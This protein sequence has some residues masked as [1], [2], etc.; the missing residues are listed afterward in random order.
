LL[1][2]FWRWGLT[3]YL[4]GLASH[5]DPPN[6]SLPSSWDY[7]CEPL[8]PGLLGAYIRLSIHNPTYF[9]HICSSVTFSY[10]LFFFTIFNGLH[11][12]ISVRCFYE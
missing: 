3:N 2:L 9:Y 10:P 4:P 12:S 1:W 6:P 7:R 8:V 5:L 11:R